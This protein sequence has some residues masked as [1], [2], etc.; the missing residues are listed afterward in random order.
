MSN[1]GKRKRKTGQV[2]LEALGGG[3]RHLRI[4]SGW[5]R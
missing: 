1:M 4:S 3:G 5:S 2:A